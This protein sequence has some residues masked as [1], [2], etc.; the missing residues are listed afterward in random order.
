MI[1]EQEAYLLPGLQVTTFQKELSLSSK[2]R[3]IWTSGHSPGTSCLYHNGWGG[4]LFSGRHLVPDRHGN[5]VPLKTAKTFHWGRQIRSVQTL[6]DQLTPDTMQHLC[7]GANTGFLR[8]KLTID[9]AYLKLTQ[10]DLQ[11]CLAV[12]PLL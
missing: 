9:E 1:Q 6:L 3:V 10:L 7:P 5:P 11:V 4:V 8:G 12:Q 2:S